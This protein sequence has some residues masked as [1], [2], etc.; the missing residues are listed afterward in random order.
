MDHGGVHGAAAQPQPPGQFGP[1]SAE[2]SDKTADHVSGW[3]EPAELPDGARVP[4]V[5]H[6]AE[7]ERIPLAERFRQRVREAAAE[8][9][10]SAEGR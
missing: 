3:H 5:R 10:E 4:R 2:F 6:I 8:A 7:H 9:G 1:A